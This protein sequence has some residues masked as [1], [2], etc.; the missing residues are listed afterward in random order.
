MVVRRG[1]DIAMTLQVTVDARYHDA[2]IFNLDAVLSEIAGARALELTIN[3]VRKLLDAGV[4]TAV[5]SL[6]PGGQQLLKSAGIGDLFGVC[7]HGLPDAALVEA[8][9]RLGV[10]P[11][12]VCR[13][14]RCRR[15]HKRRPRT[16]VSR[17][18][19]AST[20]PGTRTDYWDAAPMS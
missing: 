5:H 20:P 19:S 10:R 12:L 16:A 7:L 9:R 4:S 3:L 6:R 17:S 15:R 13:R 18:S 8:T 1:K 11:Q 14:R 2:V